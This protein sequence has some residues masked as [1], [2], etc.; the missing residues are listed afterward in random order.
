MDMTKIARG[1]YQYTTIDDCSRSR[2][3]DV[4]P[5]RNGRNALYF[6]YRV[7]EEMP[8]PIQRTQTDRGG[9]FFAESVQRRL[10]CEDISN[11]DRFHRARHT[12]RP[13]RAFATD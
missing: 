11:F 9:E 13:G 5:S 12:S 2:V 3:L 10:M 1:A 7:I 6:L 4:Y 8:F